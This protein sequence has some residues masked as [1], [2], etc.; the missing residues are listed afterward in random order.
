LAKRWRTSRKRV[1]VNLVRSSEEDWLRKLIAKPKIF[2]D[3]LA[4]L[5]MYKTSLYLNRLIYVGM[6]ILDQ[7]KL[8]MYD[9]YYNKMRTKYRDRVT[10]LYTDT[11]SLSMHIETE[12]IYADMAAYPD[13]YDT[14]DYPSDHPLHN[15][16]NK[17]VIAKMKDEFAGVPVAEFVG[18]RPKMYSILKSDSKELKKAKGMQKNVVKQQIRHQQYKESLFEKKVFH[19]GMNSLRSEGHKIYSLHINKVSLS[20]MDTKRWI[21][22]DGIHTLA[23][24]HNDDRP[25]RAMLPDATG[26]G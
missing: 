21:A 7:S 22:E 2:Y 14:S 23:H 8:L 5:H 9:F 12:D 17:R 25:A 1:D 10:L 15:T 3:D 24:G 6:S 13:E 4:A 20:P 26:M 18:L 16:R 19:H 11:D